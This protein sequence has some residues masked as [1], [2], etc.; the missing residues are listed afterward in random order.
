MAWHMLRTKPRSW[1]CKQSEDVRDLG[2]Y[3]DVDSEEGRKHME[4][5]EDSTA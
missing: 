1:W 3:I 2:Q 5:T 4:A